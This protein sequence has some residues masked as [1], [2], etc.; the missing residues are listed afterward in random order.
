MRLSDIDLRLLL[1]AILEL[2]EYRDLD[3]FLSAV[4]TILGRVLP[5]RLFPPAGAYAPGR[6]ARAARRAIPTQAQRELLRP[7]E[8]AVALADVVFPSGDLALEERDRR[9][10]DLLRPHFLL[11]CAN[12]HRVSAS[13][14]VRGTPLKEFGL[15]PREYDVARWLAAGKTNAE[16]ASILGASARTIEKHVER[17]LVKLGVE[18][19]TA[20]ALLVASA[21]RE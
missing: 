9:V 20:A 8:D 7:R 14:T 6:S 11:A 18:N 2:H 16:I 1:S 12:A 19:R 3:E 21:P 4:P 5:P 13:Q 10:L 15:T 17:V